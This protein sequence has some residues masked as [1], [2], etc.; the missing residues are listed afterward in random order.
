M[1][2]VCGGYQML[3]KSVSDPHGMEGPPDEIEGLGL[4]D[5][6]TVLTGEKTLTPGRRRVPH[7]RRAV[8]RL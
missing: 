6:A 4:L 5:V 1:L 3:G 7:E 8:P 2:G